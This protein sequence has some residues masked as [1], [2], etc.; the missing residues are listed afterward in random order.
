MAEQPVPR[1]A[2]HD[3]NRPSSTA[4]DRRR[5]VDGP[6]VRGLKTIEDRANPLNQPIYLLACPGVDPGA[7]G[8]RFLPPGLDSEV[9]IAMTPPMAHVRRPAAG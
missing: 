9:K 1:A 7:S 8:R 6:P 4:R 5:L 3:V 2:A